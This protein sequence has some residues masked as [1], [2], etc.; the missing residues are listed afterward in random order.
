MRVC[1]AEIFFSFFL[2][3][4]LSPI[5]HSLLRTVRPQ[6]MLASSCVLFILHGYRADRA[7]L[8]S[9]DSVPVMPVRFFGKENLAAA[10]L[11]V[12]RIPS[13]LLAY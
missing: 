13:V 2:S 6:L 10:L 12:K 11:P 1:A 8:I 4:F 9:K 7:D 3:F 5:K